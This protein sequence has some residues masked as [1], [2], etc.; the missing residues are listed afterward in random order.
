MGFSICKTPLNNNHS[1]IDFKNPTNWNLG[2]NR[3]YRVRRRCPYVCVFSCSADMLCPL[4]K[5]RLNSTEKS[6]IG[7]F[8][9]GR[10]FSKKL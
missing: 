1:I 10:T 2:A 5:N 8:S 7:R 4:K 6:T 9:F 3:H